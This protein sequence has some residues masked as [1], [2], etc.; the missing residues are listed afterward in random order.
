[1]SELESAGGPPRALLF[2]LDGTIADSVYVQVVAWQR[3]LAPRGF[4]VPAWRIH[5]LLGRGLEAL[6]EELGPALAGGLTATEAKLIGAAHAA[7]LAPL[8]GGIAPCPGTAE[9]STASAR[10]ELPTAIVT[11]GDRA[12]AEVLLR[13]TVGHGEWPLFVAGVDA[14]AKPAPDSIELAAGELGVAAR[15]C[16]CVGD[17]VWDM[18]AAAAAGAV[19]LGVL[20]GGRSAAD[21]REAGAREVFDDLRGVAAALDAANRGV[22]R[23]SPAPRMHSSISAADAEGSR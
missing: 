9:L 21:L 17:S 15:D 18:A 23:G 7:A 6:E 12:T 16:W 22:H 13:A 10:W 20:S 3:A 11:G 14:A 19:P 4:A 5:R 8:L 1:V 2:D